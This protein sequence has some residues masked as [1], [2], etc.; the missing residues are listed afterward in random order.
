VVRGSTWRLTVDNRDLQS[1]VEGASMPDHPSGTVTFLFTDI[2]GSTRLVQELGA[3]YRQLLEEHRRRI[4]RA[5]AAA[6]GVEVSTEG[7]GIF[8]V[9]PTAIGAV[10]AAADAQRALAETGWPAG[11]QV[12]V[13]MGVHS[14][15]GVLSAGDYVGLDVHRA[16][17]IAAAANGGQVLLSHT[18]RAMVDTALPAGIDL[19]DMGLHRLKDLPQPERLAQ[20][21]IDGLPNE[22]GPIRSL[23]AGPVNLPVS[24]TSFVG[25]EREL[26]D[27]RAL[28]GASRLVT[29]VGPG[30][31]G[32]TRLAQRVASSLADA[33]ADGITF[34]DLA[35]I[36]DPS[37]VEATIAGAL[38]LRG[39]DP[40]SPHERLIEYLRDRQLLLILDN[41][42]Q[43]LAAAPSVVELVEAAARSSVLVTSRA[44]L[45]VRGE[46]TFQVPPLAVPGEVEASATDVVV[47]EAVTL[48]VDRA[49]SIRPGLTISDADLPVIGQIVA[50]L[51]GLPLAIELAA[52][53][54]NILSPKALLDRLAD[55]RTL[56]AQGARDLP[57]RQRTLQATITWS[58][59]LLDPADQRLFARFGVFVGGAD[60]DAAE[61]I[62]AATDEAGEADNTSEAG[63][64]LLDRIASLVDN[65]LIQRIE[66]STGEPR[67][68]ML[69]T[70]RA[71]ARERL[72]DDPR[73][74]DVE[75]AHAAYYLALAEAAKSGMEGDDPQ[76]WL[77]RLEL[78]LDNLRAALRWAI[79]AP[80]PELGLCLV[81]ALWRFWHLRGHITEGRRWAA[82]ILALPGRP[83]DGITTAA[84]IGAGGLAY[85]QVDMVAA[86]SYYEEGLRI[87]S[88]TA[89]RWGEAEALRNLGWILAAT[90]DREAAERSFERSAAIFEELDDDRGLAG[91][92]FGAGLRRWMVDDYPGA[93]D[94][95]ADALHRY[96]ALG[97]AYWTAT[98]RSALGQVDRVTGQLA[99]AVDQYTTAMGIFRRIGD[100]SGVA[101]EADLLGVTRLAM[102][103]VELGVRLASA[104]AALRA[105]IAASAP[106][107]LLRY[108]SA[109]ETARSIL[110]PASYE[111]ASAAGE[112]MAIDEI[113][114][115]AQ[116]PV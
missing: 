2:E 19:R 28:L 102:G 95:Y 29:L 24:L 104:A 66:T 109:L 41:F 14:G 80:D 23:E 73:R 71:F 62:A 32:K 18:T 75:R 45:R 26:T 57:A 7:D 17:R 48:F 61:R 15:E 1:S 92:A 34:V 67:L 50:R 87:A 74:A 38:R 46:Q 63:E 83:G 30:G 88:D 85:W 39:E 89:D 84:L 8:V 108:Q 79:T 13:R 100:V 6:G 107:A 96:E 3:A 111:A 33:F 11:T 65:S 12:R 27:L 20:L 113:L 58:H 5:V 37:L 70:I 40:R 44:P 60:F 43:L 51:D 77:D 115:L 68:R 81:A 105:S 72:D 69:E 16:A 59:D 42:E 110:D 99:G 36:S 114:A 47:Y 101:M 86:R 98:C 97:D 90:G 112:A 82:A 53:R 116:E 4:R 93:R 31:A 54:V 106:P 103:H 76:T 94:R 35:P 49:R 78:E 10:T 52:A 25:R 21:V 64:S 22:F 56:T 91:I 55:R 9:F